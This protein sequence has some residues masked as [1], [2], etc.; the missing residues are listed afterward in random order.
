MY[1]REEEAK[2]KH[3]VKITSTG[4]G[5]SMALK[6]AVKSYQILQ[7]TTAMSREDMMNFFE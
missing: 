2:K 3:K 1:R 4:P 5:V 7:H 6:R